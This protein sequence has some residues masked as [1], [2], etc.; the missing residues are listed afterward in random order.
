MSTDP[1][2]IILLLTAVPAAFV[3][4]SAAGMGGSL[5]LV[6]ALAAVLGT[7]EGVAL[8]ALLLAANNVIK[9]GAY[10]KTIPLRPAAM[11]TVA[12]VL[13]AAV[14][15][16]LMVTAPESWVTGVVLAMMLATF[17]TDVFPAGAARRPWAGV[18]AFSSGATSGFSGTSGPL[19]G[20]AIRSL[21][22]QRQSF[23]GAAALVSLAGDITK[24]SVFSH[25]GLLGK[26]E[27]L[28]VTALIPVM[29]AATLAGRNINQRVGERGHAVLFW[30]AMA[31]YG[32]RL[33]VA[34]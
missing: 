10:R 14:G 27:L 23:V 33:A 13:G 5:I 24:A 20:M 26:P 8:A 17:L 34:S 29:I 21:D 2:T 19:K 16:G 6:P 18:L 31:G 3:F 30:T 25:A 15:A 32:A 1:L 4:S 11:I 12:A 9:L 28:L 22:L 7:R